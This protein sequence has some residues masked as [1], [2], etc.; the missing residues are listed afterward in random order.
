MMMGYETPRFE[1]YD[2]QL[3]S[4]QALFGSWDRSAGVSAAVGIDLEEEKHVKNI[5]K[6]FNFLYELFIS[7]SK[8]K[9]I[10]ECRK[11]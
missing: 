3:A 1:A 4:L 6:G 7:T 11:K 5:K 8:L 10:V 9:T 2:D